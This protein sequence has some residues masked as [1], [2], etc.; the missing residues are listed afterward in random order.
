MRWHVQSE[1]CMPRLD[2]FANRLH[3]APPATAVRIATV[4]IGG[5]RV[6]VRPPSSS[7]AAAASMSDT[8]L[9]VAAREHASR[10][11]TSMAASPFAPATYADCGALGSRRN[12]CVVPQPQEP[13]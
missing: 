9:R 4:D 13:L 8:R 6:P 3:G 12:A 7:V 1:E 11:A 10:R 2:A 5:L